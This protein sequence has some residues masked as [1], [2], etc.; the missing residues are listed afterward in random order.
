MGPHPVGLD[1]HA[2]GLKKFV[3]HSTPH[4]LRVSERGGGYSSASIRL[5][6]EAE[7]DLG[8]GG[9]LPDR[10]GYA[11]PEQH[12]MP[13]SIEAKLHRLTPDTDTARSSSAIMPV[14]VRHP[15]QPREK[16]AL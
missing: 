10:G 11:R 1:P 2:D 14:E 8:K 16:L 15:A 7:K 4:C 6:T 12:A 5:M 3:V 13:A 9:V